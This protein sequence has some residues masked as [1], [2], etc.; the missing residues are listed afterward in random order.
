MISVVIPLY[1]K[2][3]SISKTI[4]SVL[5]QTFIDF[6]VIIVND[7]STDNSLLHAQSIVDSRIR[8]IDKKNG[9]VSSARNRGIQES[10]FEYIAFLDG[11][12]VWNENHLEVIWQ[13]I[14]KYGDVDV[15]G[16]V[17]S[18]KR[19]KN[20]YND[21]EVKQKIPSNYN[22]YIIEDYFL[23]SS[24]P[25]DIISST[26]FVVKKSLLTKNYHFNESLKYGEDVEFWYKFFRD[27]KLVKSDAITAYYILQAENRSDKNIIGLE[28]RFND[29]DFVGKSVSEKKYLGKLVAIMILDYFH[30]RKYDIVIKT[31]FKYY[32]YI[33]YVGRYFMLLVIKKLNR[34]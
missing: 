15:G 16:Y 10:T 33:W 11:D 5:N 9:G 27:F 34:T 7:G 29:F 18:F 14:N 6:E 28:F 8:I 32:K 20:L 26:N 4:D 30:F 13:L 1:N 24:T 21:R 17:T 31:F 23:E 3:E 12:D 19:V 22:D 2:Q 25:K